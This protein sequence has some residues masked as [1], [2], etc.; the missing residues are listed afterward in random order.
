MRDTLNA[1]IQCGLGL[2]SR[3]FLY[4]PWIKKTYNKQGQVCPSPASFFCFF[5]FS[6][7][8][9]AG[10]PEEIQYLKEKQNGVLSTSISLLFFLSLLRLL[11]R[12]LPWNR[13][14]AERSEKQIFPERLRQFS[15]SSWAPF[16]P[17]PLKET[18]CGNKW[19]TDDLRACVSFLFLLGLR[20]LHTWWQGDEKIWEDII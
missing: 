5:V 3:I 9:S 7:A 18:E 4:F 14:G 15:F 19:K 1:C 2:L 13:Q 8:G 16:P 10:S 6:G 11:S 12:R 17:T 20:C